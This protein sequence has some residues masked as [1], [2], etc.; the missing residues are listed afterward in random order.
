MEDFSNFITEEIFIIGNDSKNDSESGKP[1]SFDHKLAVIAGDISDQE[2]DLLNNI[3]SALNFEDKD[4]IRTQEIDRDSSK[5]WLIFSD[6]YQVESEVLNFN[7][8]TQLGNNT[9]LLAQP[10]ST[11]RE[12]QQEKQK[13][14]NALKQLFNV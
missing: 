13:L 14:W 11:L 9:F 6:T 5:I 1:A 8:P 4:I 7:H 2:S 12:S 3:L 10:L